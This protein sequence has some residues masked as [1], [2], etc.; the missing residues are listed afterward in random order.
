MAVQS[1]GVDRR[2]MFCSAQ[3]S[4]SPLYSLLHRFLSSP[5][6]WVLFWWRI[7]SSPGFPT[8]SNGAAS[9][10]ARFEMCKLNGEGAEDQNDPRYLS[11]WF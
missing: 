8:G 10:E 9:P 5:N 1:R 11:N 4:S 6:F 3:G 2:G 7:F